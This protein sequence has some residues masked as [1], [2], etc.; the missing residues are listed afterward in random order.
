[1]KIK[2]ILFTLT[3]LLCIAGCGTIGDCVRSDGGLPG[4]RPHV[5]GGVKSD[6]IANFESCVG[7]RSLYIWMLDFPFSFILDTALLPITVPVYLINDDTNND[8][9]RMPYQDHNDLL[10]PAPRTAPK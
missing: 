6:Y 9:D 1:M 3:I 8:E 5:Y 4:P 10:I 7:P 2:L